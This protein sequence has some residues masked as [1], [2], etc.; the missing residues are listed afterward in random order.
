MDNFLYMGGD[1]AMP[2]ILCKCKA[3]G[4]R[5]DIKSMRLLENGYICMVC[6]NGWH[7][8]NFKAEDDYDTSRLY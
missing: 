4:N 8:D 5:A 7:T 3:C 6:W 1:S 2:V